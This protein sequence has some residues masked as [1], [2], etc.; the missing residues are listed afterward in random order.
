MDL[1][2]ESD[3]YFSCEK[4]ADD[5]NDEVLMNEATRAQ[6]NLYKLSNDFNHQ[7][8]Q[9][10]SKVNQKQKELSS[11]IRKNK[12]S[13]IYKNKSIKWYVGFAINSLT[14]DLEQCNF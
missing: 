12:I 13:I 6:D 5:G 1:S 4:Y 9:S 10:T 8:K 3:C 7:N 11:L 2:R 14:S